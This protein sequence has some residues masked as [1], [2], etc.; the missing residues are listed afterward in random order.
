MRSEIVYFS[1]AFIY[2]CRFQLPPRFELGSLDS[3][4]NVIT[5]YTMGACLAFGHGDGGF[6]SPCLSH[7]KR[8][9]YQLSYTPGN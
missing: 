9:L 7:A 3:K 2:C 1:L 8:A 6:R 4:S 5:N